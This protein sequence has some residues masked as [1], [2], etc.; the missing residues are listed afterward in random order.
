M[1]GS[2]DMVLASGSPRRRELLRSLGWAFRTD[3]CDVCE[4]LLP[5][6]PPKDAVLRLSR[7]KAAD[8]ARRNTDSLVIAADTLVSVDG[9]V[10]GKPS[11]REESFRMISS[12]SGREHTVF[13]GLALRRGGLE[14][15][16]VEETAVVFRSLS[17]EAMR[18]YVDSGEGDDK[19]GAYAI[20]GRGSLLVS[21]IRG[22]F[23]NV[24][25]LPLC[26]L[27]ELLAEFGCTLA[28]QWRNPR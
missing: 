2:V 6:E 22:D 17:D 1:D 4:D 15:F 18:A 24:V 5:G 13:T 20:Q 14:R 26:R 28:E 3:V 23:F 9:A 11:C 21:S 8:S 10:L 19:A 27:S 16:A 12:L 7:A 25:G